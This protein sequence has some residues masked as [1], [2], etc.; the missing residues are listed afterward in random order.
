MIGK[1]T[2]FF[3]EVRKEGAKVTWPTRKET[4]MTVVMVVV[5]SS[6]MGVFFLMVDWVLAIASRFL[7]NLRF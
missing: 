3:S 1:I 4:T 6:V 7:I 2:T 5:L